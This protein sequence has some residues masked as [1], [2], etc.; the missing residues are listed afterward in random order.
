MAVQ[1]RAVASSRIWERLS[2]SQGF[3]HSGEITK[4]SALEAFDYRYAL[5][6][7]QRLGLSRDFG[8]AVAAYWRR[9]QARDGFRRA[10]EAENLAG[11]QQKVARRS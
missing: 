9:L 11:D 10:V 4:P 3:C 2:E 8:S 6:L 7:A 5:L 1:D